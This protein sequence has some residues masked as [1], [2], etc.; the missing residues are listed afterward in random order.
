MVLVAAFCT[1]TRAKV[2]GIVSDWVTGRAESACCGSTPMTASLA[3]HDRVASAAVGD[4]CLL[5]WAPVRTT[6]IGCGYLGVTHA[7]CMAELGY[8]VLGV[9]I[10]PEKLSML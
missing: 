8:D 1:P 7:A 2:M 5:G 3:Q 9:E 4:L 10:D 6:T